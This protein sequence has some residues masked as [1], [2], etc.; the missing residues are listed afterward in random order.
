MSKEI[1]VGKVLINKLQV[2]TDKENTIFVVQC[3]VCQ[4]PIPD[5]QVSFCPICGSLFS[6]T[7]DPW[8]VFPERGAPPKQ[9]QRR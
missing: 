1:K 3:S 6:S 5:P 8:K 2:G 7:Y 4:Q 9:T